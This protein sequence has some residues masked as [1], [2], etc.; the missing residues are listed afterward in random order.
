MSRIGSDRL[1]GIAYR[2]YT[3]AVAH[4]Q[5]LDLPVSTTKPKQ[6]IDMPGCAETLSIEGRRVVRAFWEWHVSDESGG[7]PLTLISFSFLLLA[8]FPSHLH[9]PPAFIYFINLITLFLIN[10]H[11]RPRPHLVSPHHI[12]FLHR[13][14]GGPHDVPPPPTVR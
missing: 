3:A 6:C 7:I 2:M 13:H 4:S 5:M 8:R 9:L 1:Y 11:N 12:L 10:H 14:T